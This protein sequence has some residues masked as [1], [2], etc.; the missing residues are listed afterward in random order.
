MVLRIIPCTSIDYLS[1]ACSKEDLLLGSRVQN[2]VQN[3]YMNMCMEMMEFT[4]A[5]EL[6]AAHGQHPKASMSTSRSLSVC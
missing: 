3:G 4:S 1:V 6:L 5:N 2:R